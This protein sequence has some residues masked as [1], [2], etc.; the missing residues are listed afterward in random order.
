MDTPLR[1]FT[2]LIKFPRMVSGIII[3][4]CIGI[5]NFTGI[6]SINGERMKFARWS[7]KKEYNELQVRYDLLWKDKFYGWLVLRL[8][9]NVNARHEKA[10]VHYIVF[11]VSN[12]YDVRDTSHRSNNMT[13]SI[14]HARTNYSPGVKAPSLPVSCLHESTVQTV[15]WH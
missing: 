3:N 5:D 13:Y 15:D 6:D 14:M 4:N 8:P 7:V 12:Q 9:G 1:F 2:T 11:N 10:F